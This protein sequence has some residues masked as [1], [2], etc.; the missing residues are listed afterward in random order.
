LYYKLYCN[1]NHILTAYIPKFNKN[2]ELNINEMNVDATDKDY[3]SMLSPFDNIL[4]F[5]AIVQTSKT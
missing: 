5:H 4:S 3:L 1:T 2:T